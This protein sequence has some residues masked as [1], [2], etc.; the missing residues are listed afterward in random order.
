MEYVFIGAVL[1]PIT[2]AAIEASKP[3]ANE[4]VRLINDG[5]VNLRHKPGLRTFTFDVLL[6]SSQSYPFQIYE[7]GGMEATLFTRYFDLLHDRGVPVPFITVSWGGGLLGNIS[8]AVS[9]ALDLVYGN[10]LCTI[11]EQTVSRDADNGMDYVVSL[12]LKEYRDY[13]TT[14]VKEDKEKST[15]G[16]LV[17]TVSSKT[18]N[19]SWQQEMREILSEAWGSTVDTALGWSILRIS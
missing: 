3:G 19:Y 2:P 16:K 4:T 1:L 10:V 5:E 8:G 14:Y 11:E 18:S 7:L 17:Y 12:T 15:D 6:P 13:G 9:G